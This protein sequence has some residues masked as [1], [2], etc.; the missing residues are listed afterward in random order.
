MIPYYRDWF[1]RN[2]LQQLQVFSNLYPPGTSEMSRVLAILDKM[3]DW[4]E[5][6]DFLPNDEELQLRLVLLIP[7]A[8]ELTKF[9]FVALVFILPIDAL[10]YYVHPSSHDAT[11]RSLADLKHLAERCETFFDWRY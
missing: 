1:R 11:V 4:S 9:E 5:V 7:F 2:H 3:P 10:K 6:E 8:P